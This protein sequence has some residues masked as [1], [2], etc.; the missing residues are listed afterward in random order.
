MKEI[1]RCG[2]S[3]AVLERFDR[4]IIKMYADA[5]IT[6]IEVALPFVNYFKEDWK[7]LSLYAEESGVELW[8]VHL[9]FGGENNMYNIADKHYCDD[10]VKADEELLIKAGEAG[11]RAAV[12]HPNTGGVCEKFREEQFETAVKSL[13]K[14]V[15]IGRREGVDIAAEI[16]PPY[17]IGWCIDEMKRLTEEVPDLKICMDVNHILGYSHEK[18]VSAFADK[19]VTVHMSDCD[20]EN[21]KHWMPGN[22]KI[23]WKNIIHLLKKINYTGPF[24]Y[25]LDGNEFR[26]EGLEGIKKNYDNFIK[27]FINE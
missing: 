17:N 10:T 1:L 6:S 8:S 3:C 21:E 15:R 23:D 22:G 18:F 5:G 14:L 25:E 19:I 7:S 20:L 16:L 12:I 11:M 2:S 13:Q 4:E 26:E 27:G 24:M 9:P